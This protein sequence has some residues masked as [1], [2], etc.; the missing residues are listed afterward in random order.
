MP[1]YDWHCPEG[2]IWEVTVPMRERDRP[3]TCPD[4]DKPGTRLLSAVALPW[5]PSASESGRPLLKQRQSE[6]N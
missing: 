4:C 1:T 5:T 6:G 2:H 3:Q